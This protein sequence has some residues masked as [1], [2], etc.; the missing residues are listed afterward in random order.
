MIVYSGSN[1]EKI[2]LTIYAFSQTHN[3]KNSR[4]SDFNNTGGWSKDELQIICPGASF[5]TKL[6]WR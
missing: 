2:W 3:K 5:Y 4:S 6:Y 1:P